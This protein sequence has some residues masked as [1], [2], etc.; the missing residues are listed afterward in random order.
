[1]AIKLFGYTIGKEEED[2]KQKENVQS[3]VAPPNDDGSVAVVG[4][5]V[6][7]IYTDLEG[8]IR[9]DAQLIQRYRDISR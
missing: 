7:G 4:G 3:F 2:E 9:N 8:V 5:G 1:M 6:Y